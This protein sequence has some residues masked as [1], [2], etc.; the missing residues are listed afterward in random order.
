MFFPFF[1][2]SHHEKINKIEASVLQ[3]LSFRLDVLYGPRNPMISF[4]VFSFPAPD[5][6]DFWGHCEENSSLTKWTL[7]KL[8]FGINL[9]NLF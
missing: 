4:K 8:L 3:E 5:C 6:I 9:V 7:E 1:L 2:P